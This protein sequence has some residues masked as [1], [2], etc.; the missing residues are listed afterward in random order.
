MANKKD[1]FNQIRLGF[2]GGLVGTIGAAGLVSMGGLVAHGVGFVDDRD[3]DDYSLRHRFESAYCVD[4][5]E[6]HKYYTASYYD[7]VKGE[8]VTKQ[9]RYL[10][11]P[12]FT[13]PAIAA[14][15][16]LLGAFCAAVGRTGKNNRNERTR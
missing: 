16:A 1:K 11:S 10:A 15:G 3:L 6:S 12:W 2:I 8:T 14:Y 5:P 9:E 13:Y 4:V 7:Q